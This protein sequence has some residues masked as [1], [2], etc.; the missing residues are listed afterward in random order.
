MLAFKVR[1]RVAVALL[2]A[3]V[4]FEACGGESFQ[5][6]GS[7]GA[8]HAGAAAD[9]GSA[10]GGDGQGGADAGASN[11]GDAGTPSAGTEAGGASTGGTGTGGLDIGGTGGALLGGSGG[12][13][14][15][16]SVGLAGSAGALGTT[17]SGDCKSDA[18]CPNGKCVELA[19]GGFRTCEVTVPLATKCVAGDACC[20]D[21]LTKACL[22]GRC[23][24]GPA[25]PS[26]G[27]PEA[28]RNFCAAAQ[29]TSNLA[30]KD[31]NT[32]APAGTLGRKEAMCLTGSCRLDSDCTA[33]KGGKC[34]P[35]TLPCC[36]GVSGL[37]CVYPGTGC[38]SSADCNGGTCQLSSDGKSM[39]CQAGGVSCP[40]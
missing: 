5:A 18:D 29:C 32:C 26:C 7:R 24:L 35:V 36:D 34:E 11:G 19:L 38:R 9:A 16:G 31:K 10:Q 12:L 2:L 33:V 13:G 6:T 3:G 14:H 1:G 28:S 30:C 8:G 21:D 23:V 22:A 20:P 27:L 15:G 39:A 4:W 40:G 37:Y 25:A 17:N